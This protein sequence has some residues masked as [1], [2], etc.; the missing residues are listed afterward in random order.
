MSIIGLV[1]LVTASALWSS[2]GTSISAP[3]PVA[4]SSAF[5]DLD[6]PVTPPPVA[7]AGHPTA[8]ST[9][10]PSPAAVSALALAG[11][12]QRLSYVATYRLTPATAGLSDFT[13]LVVAQEG[14]PEGGSPDEWSY[15]LSW[16]DGAQV[17]MV[18]EPGQPG[19]RPTYE[20]E[21]P[22]SSGGWQCQGP[23]D[24]GGNYGVYLTEPF[25]PQTQYGQLAGILPTSQFDEPTTSSTGVVAGQA[26]QCVTNGGQT[27]CLTGQGLFATFSA[28]HDFG[29]LHGFTGQL[30]SWTESVTPAQFVL[31]ARPLPGAL[32][33]PDC[34]AGPC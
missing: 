10:P 28:V 21:R 26:V 5:T 16:A 19:S 15:T 7:P 17:E 13:T 29:V 4:A 11:A 34:N 14:D 32:D 6:P 1:G 33:L 8:P 2:V 3:T 22:A 20:C 31:P 12:G 18:Q 24:I 23:R 9:V 25:V 30:T 27:W